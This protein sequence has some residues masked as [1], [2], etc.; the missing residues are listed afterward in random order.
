M[1]ADDANLKLAR[2][3]Y[4]SCL[5][6]RGEAHEET[7]LLREYISNLESRNSQAPG[8]HA[9]FLRDVSARETTFVP[10]PH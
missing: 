6:L 3:L 2:Q 1:A 5:E 7:R 9:Q 10:L 8:P 4:E